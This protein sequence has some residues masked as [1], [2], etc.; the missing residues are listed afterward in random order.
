MAFLSCFH[1]RFSFLSISLP[2]RL[3]P[4]SISNGSS[5]TP[6]TCPRPFQ[7]SSRC[8]CWWIFAST[9]QPLW[10]RFRVCVPLYLPG[11]ERSRD[12]FLGS[13]SALCF[14]SL[15]ALQQNSFFR[16]TTGSFFSNFPSVPCVPINVLPPSPVSIFVKSCLVIVYGRYINNVSG[17]RLQRPW[18]YANGRGSMTCYIGTWGSVPLA[19]AWE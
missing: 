12:R 16:Q 11:S 9:W 1:D 2:G 18:R 19:C 15:A 14:V 3:K 8:W 5:A 4:E 17:A 6:A 7:W 13:R 10:S